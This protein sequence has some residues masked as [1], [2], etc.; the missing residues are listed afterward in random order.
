ML[1]V[2][3]VMA[4]MLLIIV[5]TLHQRSASIFPV[6]ASQTAPAEGASRH[7]AQNDARAFHLDEAAADRFGDVGPGCRLFGG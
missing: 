2:A 5:R 4:L 7:P 3:S 1:W 6:L